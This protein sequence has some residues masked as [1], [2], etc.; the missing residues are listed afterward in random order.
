MTD[1]FESRPCAG[2]PLAKATHRLMTRLVGQFTGPG[3][4]DGEWRFSPTLGRAAC[5]IGYRHA[6]PRTGH[7][8]NDLVPELDRHPRFD[9]QII[10]ADGSR[11][12]VCGFRHRSVSRG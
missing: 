1:R 10:E 8:G 3:P 4:L 6:R 2:E 12:N 5:P 7:A 11:L 9:R